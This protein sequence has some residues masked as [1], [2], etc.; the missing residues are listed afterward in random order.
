MRRSLLLVLTLLLCAPAEALILDSGDGQGNTSAPADDPGWAHVGMVTGPTG[1]YLGNGW[2]LTANHVSVSDPIFGGVA[3]PVVPGSIVQ[4]S[5]PDSSPADLKVFRIDPSPALPLLVIRSTTPGNNTHL[6]M[7]AQGLSRGAATTWGIYSGYL[8]G[9]TTGKRWGTNRVAGTFFIGT[10][11]F[12]T[13]FTK[14]TQGGT[15]HEAQGADGDSGGAVF[16]KNGSIWELAGVL[17]AVGTYADQPGATALY[18]NETYAADLSVYR[19]QLIALTRPECSNGV[20]DDGDTFVDWPADPQ[21]SSELDDTELPDQDL[22]GV[23][24]A[25]DNCPAVANPGQENFDG[26]SEGDTCDADDDNDGLLDSV[27]TNT[28]SYVS[29]SDTGS[30]PLDADSDDDGYADGVE[31]TNGWNPNDP[32]SPGPAVPALPFWGRL[33]LMGNL[34]LLGVCWLRRRETLTPA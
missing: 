14:I 33:L 7:I 18:G 24:D 21:C 34:L 30:N 8:W 13:I 16:I 10:W 3:Y 31:V 2:V 20:D 4:L 27:E 19:A 15:T 25:S 1:I 9:A 29:P 28:G 22:D 6:T 32:L 17:L 12:R 11:S 26:D 5:N 23:P